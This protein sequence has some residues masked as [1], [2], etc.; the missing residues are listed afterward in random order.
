MFYIKILIDY[1]KIWFENVEPNK[2]K[3]YKSLL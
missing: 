3:Y 2:M 1:N